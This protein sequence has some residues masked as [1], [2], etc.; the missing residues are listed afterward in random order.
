MP[1]GYIKPIAPPGELIFVEWIAIGPG[2]PP[3]RPHP[4]DPNLPHPEHP[5]SLP[6][7]PGW[8][9]IPG[10]GGP[11]GGLPIGPGHPDYP[12]RPTP[13]PTPQANAVV[14]PA[15]P[16]P[17]GTPPETPPTGLPAGSSKVFV[18]LNP[19]TPNA[20]TTSGWLYPYVQHHPAPSPGGAARATPK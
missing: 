11:G 18:Q 14:I 2:S 7:D 9:Q 3:D 8:G 19:G 13:A 17:E 1:Y 5:I 10:F 15:P 16:P 6:G 4:G 12:T 20:V